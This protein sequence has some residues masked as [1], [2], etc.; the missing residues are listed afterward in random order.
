MLHPADRWRKWVSSMRI[1]VVD[2]EPRYLRLVSYNMEAAGYEVVTAA[3]GEDALPIIAAQELDLLILDVRL[4]GI[5]GFEVCRRVREFSA[6]PIIMLTAKGEQ[7]DKIAGLR[8]G[9]D[10]YV[11]KPFAAG[12]LVARVEAVLRRSHGVESEARNTVTVGD[13]SVDL[14][15][16]RVTVGDRIIEM[17]ATEYRLLRCLIVNAGRVLV[18]EEI[19]KE[20]WGPEFREYYE[21]L[22][23]MVWRLR[24]KIEE[25]PAHP[26]Y[27]ITWPRVGYVLA[28]P[29]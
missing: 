25:D 15:R 8:G 24:H 16:R 7:R 6:V 28:V 12:E 21:G 23:V 18:H 29:E 5:D 2:D 17:T 20:V 27:I 1:L 10:D 19:Q 9:A 22:R 11:T 26:R 3:S 13:L 14:A 4:P